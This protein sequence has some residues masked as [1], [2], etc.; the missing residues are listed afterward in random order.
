VVSRAFARQLWGREDVVGEQIERTASGFSMRGANES[1]REILTVVG[2]AGDVGVVP[3]PILYRNLGPAFFGATIVVRGDASPSVMQPLVDDI[4]RQY[5]P[6]RMVE[7]MKPMR[8]YM[9]DA[10]RNERARS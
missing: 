9:Y 3:E 10:L 5:M 7:T 8:E 2:V 4:I 6:S 1:S